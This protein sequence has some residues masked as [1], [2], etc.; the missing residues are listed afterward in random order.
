MLLSE[1]LQLP[2][3]T[4]TSPANPVTATLTVVGQFSTDQ[5]GYK[6]PVQLRDDNNVSSEIIVQSK[7]EKGLMTQNMVGIRARWR[8]KWYQGQGKQVI[9]GYCL[10]KMD[11]AQ[12]TQTMPQPAASQPQ[13][14]P[15][16]PLQQ[17]NTPQPRDYDAENRGKCRTQF[18]KAAIISGQIIIGPNHTEDIVWWT[19]F[20]MTGQVP[21]PPAKQQAGDLLGQPALE[22]P[23][24]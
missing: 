13:Q 3:K 20:A 19:E 6:Q 15:P 22:P 5:Y 9:V 24:F 21:L 2:E 11:G 8:L 1:V 18:V 10:D 17:P 12:Q 7:Y 4:W 23:N 16:Q 14:A